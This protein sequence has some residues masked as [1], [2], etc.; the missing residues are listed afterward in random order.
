V[1]ACSAGV[2]VG[3][4]G[5]AVRPSASATRAVKPPRGAVRLPTD[6]TTRW[7]GQT[8]RGSH[9]ASS[10]ASSR[11]AWGH[12]RTASLCSGAVRPPTVVAEVPALSHVPM[13]ESTGSISDK[14]S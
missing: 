3:A 13:G 10:G 5:W 9:R 6:Q 2:E 11:I 12:G 7:R 8:A 4:V 1:S 14:N